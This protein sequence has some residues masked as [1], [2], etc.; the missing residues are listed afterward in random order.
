M[1]KHASHVRFGAQKRT[2]PRLRGRQHHRVAGADHRALVKRQSPTQAAFWRFFCSKDQEQV[3]MSLLFDR[4][5]AVHRLKTVA[6]STDS[7]IGL[8]GYSGAEES[9]SP[10]DPQGE[11]VLYVGIAASIDAGTLGRKKDSALPQDVVYGPTWYI[12]CSV[13][14]PKY[15]VRDRDIIVDDEGFRYEVGQAEWGILGYRLICV[16]LEA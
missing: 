2:S 8:T 9:T 1:T 5:I 12:Y 10:S 14:L 15:S 7:A 4:T 13:Q 6:G 11:T 16:R 3:A